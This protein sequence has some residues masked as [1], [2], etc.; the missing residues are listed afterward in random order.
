MSGYPP[1]NPNSEVPYVP[2][3]GGGNTGF[4]Q[5]GANPYP[6]PYQGGNPYPGSNPYPS[7][8][9]Y[10]GGNAYPGGSGFAPQHAPGPYPSSPFGGAPTALGVPPYGSGAPQYYDGGHNPTSMT[11]A[12]V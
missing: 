10:P 12:S 5:P 8:N 1:Y 2:H 11:Q 3:V 9:P 7:G 6:D 4:V